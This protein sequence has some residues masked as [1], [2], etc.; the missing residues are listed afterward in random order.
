MKL[1]L[2]RP[3]RKK[4]ALGAARVISHPHNHGVIHWDTKPHNILLDKNFKARIG[5]FGMAI[6]MDK[7]EEK[8]V[9]K[10]ASFFSLSFLSAYSTQIGRPYD[11][12]DPE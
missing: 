3:T 4:I 7:D 8:G 2:D 11:Y 12:L 1:R 10:E 6:F 9:S 5:D